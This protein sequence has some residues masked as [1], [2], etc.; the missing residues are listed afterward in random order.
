MSRDTIKFICDKVG[1]HVVTAGDATS[2]NPRFDLEMLFLGSVG[3]RDTTFNVECPG[4][5]PTMPIAARVRLKARSRL[6][7]INRVSY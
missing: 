7:P 6:K 2:L 3:M 4:G 5:Y 1:S